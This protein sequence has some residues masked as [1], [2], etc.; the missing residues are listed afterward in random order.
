MNEQLLKDFIATAQ[1]YNY[2]WNKTFGLFP[3]LK[4]YDQ[5]VLKDYVATAEKYSYDYSKVNSLFPEF[6]F[7]APQQE[8]KKK[9]Q[10]QPQAATG[11]QAVQGTAQAAQAK[12]ATGL[13]SVASS[14]GSSSANSF[15]QALSKVTSD[16]IDMDEEDAVPKLNEI[17][18]E[19][20]FKFDQ[21]GLGD[22]IEVTAPN[23][24]KKTFKI[25][26][27][28]QEGDQQV[29]D[30]LKNWA[31]QNKGDFSAKKAEVSESDFSKSLESITPDLASK[32]EDFIIPQLQGMFGDYGFQVSTSGVGDNV[33][34][35]APNKKSITIP[36][37]RWTQKGDIESSSELKKFISENKPV[38]P[39]LTEDYSIYESRIRTE[40]DL[41]NVKK[42]FN[43]EVTSLRREQQNAVIENA[44]LEKESDRKSVV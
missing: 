34:I 38:I 6:G 22:N 37:D 26:M 39:K 40:E 1:K 36:V 33:V 8:L 19:Q 29:A 44:W 4:G 41:K 20:G 3:E 12:P 32:D 10:P 42:T 2:D 18:R 25:D 27:W 7:A 13:P 31:S 21:T 5:Q 16:I 30:E 15:S 9:E 23:G 11:A 14:S 17:F 24:Q 43:D 28:T 35:T